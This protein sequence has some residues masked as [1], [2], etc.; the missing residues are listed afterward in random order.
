MKNTA[1]TIGLICSAVVTQASVFGQDSGKTTSSAS[2]RSSNGSITTNG[3]RSDGTKGFDPG[4]LGVLGLAG[5]FG[6]A[7]RDNRRRSEMPGTH[8]T[9]RS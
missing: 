3:A 1:L 9:T 7:G 6:L 4:W 2:Q 5:L 8:A